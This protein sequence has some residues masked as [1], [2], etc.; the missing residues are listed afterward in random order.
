MGRRTLVVAIGLP[1]LDRMLV[2]LYSEGRV[3]E[4]LPLPLLG[5][6]GMLFAKS[7]GAACSSCADMT[8]QNAF[9][10]CTESCTPD[11]N[12]PSG[13]YG[14]PA[15]GTD[16]YNALQPLDT[17]PMPSA[18]PSGSGT[19]PSGAY[20]PPGYQYYQGGCYNPVDLQ[21]MQQGL[22]RLVGGSLVSAG[23]RP[24]GVAP[25]APIMAPWYK[26]PLYIALMIGGAAAIGGGIY[27]ATR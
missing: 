13:A 22:L 4:R 21:Q 6:F 17:T 16:A 23:G 3:A 8:D 18:N 9:Y 15:P 26:Q 1:D 10:T 19:A 7:L 2:S 25:V 11:N 27:Y 14:P 20:C 24:S 5:G 12:L